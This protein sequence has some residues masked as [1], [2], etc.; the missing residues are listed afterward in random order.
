M[1][2]RYPNNATLVWSLAALLPVAAWFLLTA[3]LAILRGVDISASA[4]IAFVVLATAQAFVI[5]LFAA[6]TP[7]RNAADFAV[8]AAC[9][10]YTGLPFAALF[11]LAGTLDASDAI[12]AQ[13]LLAGLA[14]GCM[15]LTRSIQAVLPA[16]AAGP[17]IRIVLGL[18]AAA[19]VVFS[20]DWLGWIS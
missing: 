13:A 3:R 15:L 6:G 2:L 5:P 11:W 8:A 16:R 7:T 19:A 9:P 14:V 1:I 4:D 18:T 20:R 12:A 10:I 17:M